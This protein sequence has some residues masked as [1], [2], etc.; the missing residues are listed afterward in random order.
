MGCKC[1][2]MIQSYLL[3]PVQMPSHG[4]VNEVSSCKID[5]D[6]PVKIK[7][8]QG[9]KILVHTSDLQSDGS[10]R[11]ESHSRTEGLL[12]PGWPAQ[13]PHPQAD[14]GGG[15]SAEKPCGT[16]NGISPAGNP[17]PQQGDQGSWART[18]HNSHPNQPFLESGDTRK[19]DCVPATS[20]QT[21]ISQTGDPG[22]ASQA[23]SLSLGEQGHVL[24][25][26]PPDYPQL[27]SP[28]ADDMDLNDGGCLF[29]NP[30]EDEPLQGSGV[31]RWK[32]LFTMEGSWDSFSEA[33]AVENLSICLQEEGPT[34]PV[35]TPDSGSEQEDAHGS[36]A[37]R[38][39]EMLDEDAA[40][41]EALAALEAATAGEDDVEEAN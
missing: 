12:E 23:E 1:C 16:V 6:S 10:L 32:G 27:C 39:W 19:E 35:P 14:P 8:K 17:A 4:Y 9:S 34:F 29:L 5:E 15:L 13:G 40:V 7:D 18:A 22:V 30:T 38:D 33:V 2:K 36:I 24:Q 26:P 3:D 28:S 41:A 20:E 21:Q 37:N 25:M 11:A 31:R